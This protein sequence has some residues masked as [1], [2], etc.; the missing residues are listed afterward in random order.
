MKRLIDHA[1]A[2]VALLALVALPAGAEETP[3]PTDPQA[4]P[5]AEKKPA[6]K[7]EKK[8]DDKKA[9]SKKK[10]S[11]RPNPNRAPLF[12][13]GAT[14]K[15][16]WALKDHLGKWILLE[17]T[18]PGCPF[19]KKHYRIGHMQAL[20]K[21]Y[22]DKG[23]LWVTICSTNP[24]HRDFRTAEQWQ[25]IAKDQGLA[26]S[27][28]LLDADGKVG[29]LYEARTTPQICIINP[30]GIRVYDGAFD[31]APRAFAK[32]A[33]MAAK[34]YVTWVMDAVLAKKASPLRRSKPY[35]CSVK[36]QKKNKKKRRKSVN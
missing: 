36:Y 29:R 6:G 33:I 8:A 21:A 13:L 22:T 14:D 10:E 15:T 5:K 12:T 4:T 28:V 7:A 26:S 27:V 2:L 34:N 32:E 20:Q 18:N 3:A 25:K 35:G 16:N 24:N 23:A 31:D 19:V 30:Q 11:V 9:K 17:W 1:A